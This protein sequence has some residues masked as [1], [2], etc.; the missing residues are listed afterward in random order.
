MWRWMCSCVGANIHRAQQRCAER[1]AATGKDVHGTHARAHTHALLTQS[2]T[3]TEHAHTLTQTNAHAFAYNHTR[4]PQH[5]STTNSR[6][7][8]HRITH[9]QLMFPYRFV[10][11]C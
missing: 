11:R 7:T 3:P 6:T 10:K 1:W 8:G 4:A 2:R 9:T 5:P